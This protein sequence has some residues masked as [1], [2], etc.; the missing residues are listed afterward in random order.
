MIIGLGICILFS[1]IAIGWVLNS[2]SSRG[3]IMELEHLIH[4]CQIHDNYI[5]CGYGQMT[6]EQKHLYDRSISNSRKRLD[7]E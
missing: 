1:G 4:H 7:L 5:N 6:T 3:Q 2:N